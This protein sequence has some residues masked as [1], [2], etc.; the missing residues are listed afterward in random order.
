M[1]SQKSAL[2][3]RK[4]L[5]LV[6][7]VVEDES[8]PV[9]MLALARVRVLVKMRAIKIAET[10]F[11]LGEMRRHPIENHAD[12]V[13]VKIVDEEHKIVGIAEAAS[14]SKVTD[15]LIAPRAIE[16]M[17]HHGEKFNVRETCM[18]NV[19][20]QQRRHLT[21]SQP[22]IAFFGHASPGTKV[23]FIFCNG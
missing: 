15:G 3:I 10:R 9:G 22:A 6:A 5:D 1:S 19:I 16:G 12:P 23:H 11:V 20:G 13:L 21:V 4:V 14:R 17:L 18:M 2:L 7:A 8:V